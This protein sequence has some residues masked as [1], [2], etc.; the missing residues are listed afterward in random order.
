MH[1]TCTPTG[2]SKEN[3]KIQ[4]GV[5]STPFLSPLPLPVSS[6]SFLST[7]FPLPVL[8]F[9]S[10]HPSP[11]LRIRSFLFQLHRRRSDWNSG[12]THGGTYYKSR[13]VEAKNTFFCIVMQVIWCLK[14]CNMT[15]MG[16]AIP[17]APNSG[18]TCPPSPP[19]DLRPCRARESGG[20]L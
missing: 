7:S 12:R 4:M 6:P 1:V 9:P 16:G 8:P 15:N 2:Y 18:G 3:L 5:F 17:R 10:L 20:A 19:R 13:A 14:F 11:A